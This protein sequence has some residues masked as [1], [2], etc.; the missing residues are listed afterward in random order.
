MDGI[1]SLNV[2]SKMNEITTPK[3]Y[4]CSDSCSADAKKIK[5]NL[6]FFY[7]E[8]EFWEMMNKKLGN[9]P[10]DEESVIITKD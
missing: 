6:Y 2:K 10:P 5:E 8:K 1:R 7:S 9:M 3:G 4:T